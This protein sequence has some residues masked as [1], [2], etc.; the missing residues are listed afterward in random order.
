M[1]FEY[2]YFNFEI[3]FELFNFKFGSTSYDR[4]NKYGVGKTFR[5]NYDKNY[6]FRIFNSSLN[7]IV[8]GF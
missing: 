1:V 6:E 2:L 3:H 8:F 4:F 7:Y 5:N